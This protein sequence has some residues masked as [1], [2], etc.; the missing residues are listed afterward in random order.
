M[1]FYRSIACKFT[2]KK[3]PGLFCP[4]NINQAQEEKKEGGWMREQ[5]E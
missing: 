2:P 4:L 1:N 3:I 5:L